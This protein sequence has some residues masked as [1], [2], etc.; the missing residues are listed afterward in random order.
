MAEGIDRKGYRLKQHRRI[1]VPLP[2]QDEQQDIVQV[3][4]PEIVLVVATRHDHAGQSGDDTEQ[5][6]PAYSG[7]SQRKGYI[8]YIEYVHHPIDPSSETCNSLVAST[9]NSIG[10]LESTSCA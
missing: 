6:Q 8:I 10:S 5:L 3:T 9:A 7:A 1:K 4:H 2:E